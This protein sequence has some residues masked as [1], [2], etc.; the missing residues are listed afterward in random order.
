[1]EGAVR[2]ALAVI[3]VPVV[4]AIGR[5]A[6]ARMLRVPLVR[7]SLGFGGTLARTSRRGVELSCG[8]VPIGVFVAIDRSA[9]RWRQLLLLP[10]GPAVLLGCGL[11]LT[12]GGAWCSLPETSAAAVVGGVV[13]GEPAAAAGM[14]DGD[15][16]VSVDGRPVRYW[17]DLQQAIAERAGRQSRFAIDRAGRPLSL[18]VTPATS[19]AEDGRAVGRIGIS[20]T[21]RSTQIGISDPRSPAALAGLRTGD[22]ITSVRGRAVTRWFELETALAPL[23]TLPRALELTVVSGA[24]AQSLE[25]TAQLPRRRVVLPRGGSPAQLGL[26]RADLFVREVQPGSPAS[27]IGLAPGDRILRIDGK[28]VLGGDALLLDLARGPTVRTVSWLPPEGPGRTARVRVRGAHEPSL[29]ARL[30][31]VRVGPPMVPLEDRGRVA[32]AVSRRHLADAYAAVVKTVRG[33]A[34]TT[35]SG[36]IVLYRVPQREISSLLWM[37]LGVN[38][39]ALAILSLLP[40]PPAPGSELIFL[41]VEAVRGRPLSPRV[42]RWAIGVGAI[43]A[44]AL[45]GLAFARDLLRA[46]AW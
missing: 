42:R 5:I 14:R 36:P 12:F 1:M 18:T 33:R 37:A 16:I 26:E 32:L 41:G 39:A 28:E 25:E 46:L 44:L 15:R 40:I 6:W 8:H 38:F 21:S 17:S 27:E 23:A 2:F 4:F 13:P 19:L 29:G 45:L 30:F 34:T 7:I 3:G 31:F 24:G 10:A 11:A 20:P 35:V 22:L 43:A 9:P